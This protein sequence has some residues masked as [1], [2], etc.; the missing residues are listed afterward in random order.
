MNEMGVDNAGRI[1]GGFA[2]RKG[3][4]GKNGMVEKEFPL[5]RWQFGNQNQ[6]GYWKSREERRKKLRKQYQQMLEKEALARRLAQERYDAEVSVANA[7]RSRLL[8]SGEQAGGEEQVSPGAIEYEA[9]VIAQTML[10]SL[11]RR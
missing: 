9:N 8:W 7:M 3:N 4:G 2:G 6:D 10:S 1:N 11:F 5:R